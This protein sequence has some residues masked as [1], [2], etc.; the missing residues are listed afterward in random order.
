MRT[1]CAQSASKALFI[2]DVFHTLDSNCYFFIF[3]CVDTVVYVC[4]GQNSVNENTTNLEC[5]LYLCLALD[6]RWSDDLL[7]STITRG[8]TFTFL[9]MQ[10][11]CAEVDAHNK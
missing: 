8:K 10:K 4:L 9:N 1:V 11:M 7:A 2:C 6:W 5:M 3:L